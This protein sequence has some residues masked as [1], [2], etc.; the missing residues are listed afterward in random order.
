MIRNHITPKPITMEFLHA[1][2][3]NVTKWNDTNIW[4]SLS[5]A[6][7]SVDVIDDVYHHPFHSIPL[8]HN[9]SMA[10]MLFITQNN[11]WS[12]MNNLLASNIVQW[13]RVYKTLKW[14][15]KNK[16]RGNT[17]MGIIV[18]FTKFPACISWSASHFR[19]W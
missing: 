17:L 11:Y 6:I 3:S 7:F 18:T 9:G 13:A 5:F 10:F 14:I 2:F 16:C 8:F 12:F 19:S 4:Y 1:G 15:M